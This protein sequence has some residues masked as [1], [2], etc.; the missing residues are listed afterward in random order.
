M[1]ISQRQACVG[2]ELAQNPSNKFEP[3]AYLIT[4]FLVNTPHDF[5]VDNGGEPIDFDTGHDLGGNRLRM[6]GTG[7]QAVAS[8][9]YFRDGEWLMINGS[10]D[11][12]AR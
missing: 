11:K 10:T 8:I 3:L 4:E 6:S 9:S 7:A 12:T 1:R 2:E 5:Q